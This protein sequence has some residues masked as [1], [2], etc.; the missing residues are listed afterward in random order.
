MSKKQKFVV[1]ATLY[2]AV[3][4]FALVL[5]LNKVPEKAR[6]GAIVR[7]VNVLG[8]GTST[9][10]TYNFGAVATTTSSV[11]VIG[12]EADTVDFEIYPE[13]ASSTAHVNIAV[14]KTT[15]DRCGTTGADLQDYVDAISRS[16]TT[17]NL[18]TISAGT[19][20]IGWAPIVNSETGKTFQITNMN[21]YCMKV[22]VGGQAVNVYIRGVLKTLNGF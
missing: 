21:A 9:S 16:A 14:L 8:T 10:G 1:G 15:L 19:S 13:S 6:A 22:F 12:D 5:L 2:F 7:T 3:I 17:A 18:T 4:G 20:T 11:I